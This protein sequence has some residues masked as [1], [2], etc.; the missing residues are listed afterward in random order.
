MAGGDRQGGGEEE[1]V[2]IGRLP[3]PG[4]KLFGRERD[5]AWLEACWKE[6]AH[7][8]TI[9]APGGV[10]KSALVWD[11]LRKMQG[12]GWDGAERVY[13]WSFYSQGTT[14]RHTSADAFISAALGW[15]GDPE[16]DA[17]G[18]RGRRGRV[19]PGW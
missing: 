2:D 16:P 18:G 10:G 15:F 8:A 14:D 1:R 19:W 3:K 17:R 7:V 6:R 13:G 4:S 5:T 11:W 9:V 12:A